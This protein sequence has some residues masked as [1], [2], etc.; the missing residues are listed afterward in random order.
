MNVTS[1]IALLLTVA[2]PSVAQVADPFTTTDP[3]DRA[4]AAEVASALANGTPDRAELD[5]LLAK[6]PRPTPLRGIVQTARAAALA[7]T[8]DTGSAVAALEEALRLLPDDPRPKLVATE[9]FTFSGSPQ[10]AADLWMRAS[11]ESPDYALMSD[12]YVMMALVGRLTDLGDHARADRVRARLGEIGFSAGLAPERSGAALARTRE[13]VRRNEE[14]DALAAVTAIADPDDLLTLYTNRQYAMLWPRIAEWAGADLAPQSQRYLEELRAD[15]AAANDFDTATAY[16]RQL[17]DLEAY[18]AVAALFLPMFDRMQEDTEVGGMEFLA[19]VVARSLMQLGRMAEAQALLAKAEAAIPGN[20]EGAAL[21]I[22]ASYL[23]LAA[24]ETDWPQVVERADTFLKRARP[25]GSSINASALIQ[26]QAWRACALSHMGRTSEAQQ[27]GAQVLLAQAVVPG[28]AME[29]LLCRGDEAAARRL[30]LARL[31]DERTLGWALHFVQPV[32]DGMRTPLDRL[33][34]PAAQ[35]VRTDAEVVAA[36]NR[37]GRILPQPVNAAL[38]PKFDPFRA[39]P[40][41]API[42]PDAV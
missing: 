14:S 23:S 11:Q 12:R 21:N 32:R 19:P 26:I 3:A 24:E 29:M 15:W 39:P 35:A 4:L 28:P 17:A 16:A 25:L 7:V 10:R 5:A 20:Q 36:A 1:A 30:L 27:E 13:A 37:V 33:M 18:A 40:K 41:S 38:P 22:A 8:R 34:K 2:T 9:V 42:D 6:L 31:A